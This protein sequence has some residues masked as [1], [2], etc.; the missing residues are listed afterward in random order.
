M[1]VTGNYKAYKAFLRELMPIE[2]HSQ[3]GHTGHA[4]ST[5]AGD[6]SPHEVTNSNILVID[7]QAIYHTP[8][9]HV[10]DP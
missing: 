1:D 8:Q 10:A 5:K 3:N 6:Q 4:S 7:S 9:Q 2:C